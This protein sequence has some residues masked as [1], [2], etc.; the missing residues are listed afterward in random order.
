MKILRIIL[1]LIIIAGAGICIY[2]YR[3]MTNDYG[4]RNFLIKKGKSIGFSEKTFVT[5]SG[6]VLS[7]LE[8]PDNGEPLL[9]I[10]GQMVSKEDY[11][12]VL[13]ELSRHFHVY[14]VDCPGH[15]KSSKAAD[16]YN[17]IAIRNDFISF[18]RDV[19][20][21]K[22]VVSGH[23][24]GAL[25]AA[26]VASEYREGVSRLILEDGPFFSTEKGRA[27][28]TFAY[29]EFRT[30][31]DYLSQKKVDS[32]TEYYLE[33]SYMKEMFN[34][35]G[36]DNWKAIIRDPFLK[37]LDK[38]SGKLPAVWY[39]PPFI[40]NLIYMTG[41]VQ[42]GTGD[43]DLMFGKAFYDFSFFD[44]F[45][46]TEELSKIECPTLIM[47]VAPDKETAPSYYDR[48]GILLSAMDEKDA[49]KVHSLIK[50]SILKSGFRSSHDIH[51]DLP[52]E[53]TESLIS[54]IK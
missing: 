6:T 49:Q 41:N 19:I 25:I 7:Y 46:Q 27:E 29:L 36:K 10:H 18:I 42:D 11:A 45:S 8:G 38:S 16:K 5:E 30:I 20:R 2:A 33:N 44:G 26:A 34:R 54:F 37:R 14:A 1:V 3:N 21:E 48:N 24:S 40:N 9:L 23:S 47:H 31:N 52:S 43:Y 28:K 50:G 13:P 15:G 39:Y 32:Y 4:N 51:A 17:I 35:D 12:G 22:T 53:F